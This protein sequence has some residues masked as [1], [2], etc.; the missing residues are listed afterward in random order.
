MPRPVLPVVALL[1]ATSCVGDRL[2]GPTA[3]TGFDQPCRRV[4]QGPVEIEEASV[5]C[6]SD[7]E[8]RFFVQTRGWTSGVTVFSQETGSKGV[9]WADQHDLET[10]K[11]GVCQDFDMLE[12]ELRTG[13]PRTPGKGEEQWVANEST[14]FS[15]AQTDEGEFINHGGEKGGVMTY[16]VRAYAVDGSLASCMVFGHDPDGLLDETYTRVADPE[17]P[18]ELKDCI[19]G[20]YDSTTKK[21]KTKK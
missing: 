1:I 17:R 4:Y 6:P 14:A 11:F 13:L 20:V 9:Q 15:C 19:K 2:A 5:T 8:V 3:D 16:L 10:F 21:G 18:E 7:E 12:Q